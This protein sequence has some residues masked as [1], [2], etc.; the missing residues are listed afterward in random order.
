MLLHSRAESSSEF[1]I[2]DIKVVSGP[3][4]GISTDGDIVEICES[5]CAGLAEGVVETLVLTYSIVGIL[6]WELPKTAVF[7][8]SNT[9]NSPFVSST[10]R[11]TTF[12]KGGAFCFDLSS[13][14]RNRSMSRR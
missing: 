10:L 7:T 5:L 11:G 8:I 1:F 14:Y 12:I 4:E 3:E 6:G 13:D 2:E 9:K